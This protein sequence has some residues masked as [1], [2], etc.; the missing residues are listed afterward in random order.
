MRIGKLEACVGIFIIM[1]LFSIQFNYYM[2]PEY[3][4]CDKDNSCSYYSENRD[5]G[6][7]K[8]FSTFD[9][10][11]ISYSCEKYRDC[12]R[13]R[14]GRHKSNNCKTKYKLNLYAGERVVAKNDYSLRETCIQQG[15]SYKWRIKEGNI[16][17]KF[18]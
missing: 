11:Q 15:E 14:T 10:N 5:S 16:T 3:I 6:K 12:P 1:T 2:N 8:I 7:K 13:N 9:G 17:F 4:S 18:E